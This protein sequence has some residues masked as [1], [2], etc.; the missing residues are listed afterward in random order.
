MSKHKIHSHPEMEQRL[1]VAGDHVIVDIEH[2]QTCQKQETEIERLREIV[3]KLF[4]A[5]HTSDGVPFSELASAYVKQLADKCNEVKELRLHNRLLK[6]RLEAI[7]QF[8]A[9]DN[10]AGAK[11]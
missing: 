4:G 10:E 6:D 9:E 8:V 3:D 2:F 5:A 7:R 1:G 11:P